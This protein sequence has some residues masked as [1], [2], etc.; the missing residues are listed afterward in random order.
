M[1]KRVQGYIKRTQK[2]ARDV[3]AHLAQGA[4]E[5]RSMKRRRILEIQPPT[6]LV[7]PSGSL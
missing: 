4:E 5:H 7:R 6:P 3:V 1:A 2:W